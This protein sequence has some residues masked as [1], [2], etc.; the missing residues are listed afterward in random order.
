MPAK[1]SRLKQ[2]QLRKQ[3]LLAESELNRAELLKELDVFKEEVRGVKNNIRLVGSLASFAAV[4]AGA[5]SIFRRGSSN[6]VDSHDRA[7]SSW[8][9]E[10]LAGARLGAS[11]FFKIK[12]LLR[13]FRKDE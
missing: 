2:L 12:S 3:L 13:S 7:K 11:L 5:I 1:T 4:L 8:I 6:R 9:S 10:A